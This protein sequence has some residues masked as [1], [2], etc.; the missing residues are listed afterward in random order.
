M[1]ALQALIHH[2]TYGNVGAG[3]VIFTVGY[4]AIIAGGMVAGMLWCWVD[5]RPMGE[6]RN[7]ALHRVASILG[8]KFV[9]ETQWS[10]R[11]GQVYDEF[12][13]FFFGMFASLFLGIL[14]PLTFTSPLI[15]VVLL[16]SL[17][18]LRLARSGLRLQ[19]KLAGHIA[20]KNAHSGGHS[21][22][23]GNHEL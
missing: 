14:T 10:T 17:V 20:D 9:E 18:A 6:F 21:T 19:K 1:N 22:N 11:A 2:I 15:G 7:Y 13:V 4:I 3:L 23:R 5:D 12:A 8:L 16:S